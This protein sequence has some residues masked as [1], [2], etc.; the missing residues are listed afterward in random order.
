MTR[1]GGST[2]EHL[3]FAAAARTPRS[4]FG[5][6]LQSETKVAWRVPLGLVLG[7]A[8]P[9]LVLVIFGTIP[10]MNKPAGSLG[11]LAYFSV[12]PP[13]DRAEALDGR[14]RIQAAEPTD[15]YLRRLP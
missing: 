10:A 6:L 3:R 14:V 8:V 2:D 7:A 15:A 11:G 5:K 4:A 13:P 9:V 12:C 1:S